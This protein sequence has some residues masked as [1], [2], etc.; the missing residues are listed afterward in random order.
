[1]QIDEARKC[2]K[3]RSVF[4]FAAFRLAISVMLKIIVSPDAAANVGQLAIVG[5]EWLDEPT[6]SAALPSAATVAYLRYKHP[7][8]TAADAAA[9][10]ATP[11]PTSAGGL[12]SARRVNAPIAA[13]AA[14]AASSSSSSSLPQPP[15]VVLH[16]LLLGGS[17]SASPLNDA[18][19]EHAAAAAAAA[20]SSPRDRN[21]PLARLRHRRLSATTTT[22]AAAVATTTAASVASQ[23]PHHH[24]HH[25]H[26]HHHAPQHSASAGSTPRRYG[27]SSA[28]SGNSRTHTLQQVSVLVK[29]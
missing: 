21:S 11:R 22:A 23:S 19:H 10:E 6:T 7:L 20:A 28:K 14:A 1:M 13:T 27:V 12:R 25:H 26:H 2:V 3:R 5:A 17:S 4:Y 16:N 15:H 29:S 9:A 8:A 18:R 24:F